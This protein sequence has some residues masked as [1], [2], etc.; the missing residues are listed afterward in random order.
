V[1]YPNGGTSTG[2]VSGDGD[3]HTLSDLN[4]TNN[5]TFYSIESF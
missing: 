3:P 2:S 4:A 1:D 5:A